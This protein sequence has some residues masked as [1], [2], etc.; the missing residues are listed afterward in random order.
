V[1]NINVSP[2]ENSTGA[3]LVYVRR[4]PDA[5]VLVQYK[6]LD[7]L[8]DGRLVFR[9][10]GR[11]DNQVA[12]MLTLENTPRGAVSANDI[13]TY[14]LGGG[15]S[16]VKFVS[17]V[18]A[19]QKRP[20]ELVPGFYFPSEYTRRLLIKPDTGPKGGVVYFVE[21]HRHISPETFARLV[22]DTWV[23]S[24]GDATTLLRELLNL[25]DSNADL[26]LAVDEPIETKADAA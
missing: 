19:R 2:Q 26:V 21:D 14:R 9:P 10:D 18:A 22:R 4:D 1:K 12:R 25:R 20:G 3:D 17:P 7:L 5:F 24:T 23:G 15:F 13:N 8:G 11:L 16:F 6:L